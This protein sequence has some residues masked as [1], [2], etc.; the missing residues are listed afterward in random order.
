MKGLRLYLRHFAVLA[1]S[2]LVLETLFRLYAGFDFHYTTVLRVVF[3]DIGMASLSALGLSLID[4]KISKWLT[5]IFLLVMALYAFIELEFKNFLNNFYSFAAVS[6]GAGRVSDY[7]M[8]FIADAPWYYW[9]V[10]IIPLAVAVPAF[11]FREPNGQ[12]RPSLKMSAL[13]IAMTV[14]CILASIYSLDH[15]NTAVDLFATY[16]RFSNNEL[17]IDKLGLE[18]FLVRDVVALFIEPERQ[19]DIVIEPTT[20]DPT[21]TEDDDDTTR[22]V[23]DSRLQS[24]YEAEE[25]A[26]IKMIDEYIL[27]SDSTQVATEYTGVFEGMN[28]IYILVESFDYMAIDPV[29]T[30]TL[31]KMMSEGY[32]FSEHYT[33]E[34]SCTTGESEFIANVSLVPYNDVCTPNAVADNAYPQALANLFKEAGY[35]TYSFHN[36]YDQYYDRR[37]E[38]A[39]FGFD[40]YYNFE[41]LTIK[42]IQG[43]QSDLSLIEAALPYFIDDDKFFTF[44]ISSSMHWPYDISSTL[45]DKYLDAIDEVYPD[46]PIEI[47]RYLSKAMEFDKAMEYLLQELEAAGK[48]E[49]TVICLFSDHDP[50]KLTTD[51]IIT[52]STLVDRSGTYGTSKTP[53]II[54]NPTLE[55]TEFTMVNS[56]FD[57]TP[58]LA[59]MFGLAYDKRLYI[60][61]NI[62]AEAATVIFPNGDWITDAGIYIVASDTFIP[63]G[64]EELS[65]TQITSINR[66]VT[67][68]IDL[69]YAIMD[70]DYFS[71]REYLGSPTFLDP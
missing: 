26:T 69:S 54:Y 33:P 23:D 1:V 66:Y 51:A 40:A 25:D 11:I 35:D 22:V 50:F 29:L 6:D 24:D 28:F 19:F 41:D 38:H 59:D 27:A 14:L 55:A 43:W 20:T 5:V 45:G 16:R 2:L 71:K 17:L 32:W 46:Y 56:T 68:A 12:D 61:D 52:Y 18:H 31:Y 48:L 4:L 62:F 44:I 8:T 58:T 64:D 67:T 53:F 63:F 15:S 42:E 21:E 9:T 49:D 13:A 39:S 47:K 70:S 3:F 57:Q 7:V 65:S 34:Y 37:T 30:P 36:W 60:G 10:F